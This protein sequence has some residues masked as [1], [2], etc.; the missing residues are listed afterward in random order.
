M[1]GHLA[2]ALLQDAGHLAAIGG[3]AQAGL[4]LEQPAEEGRVLV[5]HLVP[6]VVEVEP[7]SVSMSRRASSIRSAWTYSI[8]R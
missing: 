8:G 1:D 3:R 5:A 2:G 7:A 6:D 4:A